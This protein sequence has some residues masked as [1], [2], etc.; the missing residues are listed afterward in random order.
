MDSIFYTLSV[1]LVIGALMAAAMR[2]M[3][4][5]LIIGY[6]L[7][8]IVAGP[9]IL[10]ITKS[11]DALAVFSEIGIALLLFIVGLGLNPKAISEVGRTAALVGTIQVGVITALGYLVGSALGLSH[12]AAAFLGASVA[13]SSTIII[14]KLLSDKHEQNRLYGKIAI[15]VSLVQDLIA[16]ALVIVTSAGSGSSVQFGSTISL[17]LKGL[18]IAGLIYWFS[19]EFLPRYHKLVASSQ[20]FLFLFAIAAGLGSAALFAKIGLSSEIGALLAGVCLA[21]APYAQEIASRLRPLRDFF[22]V[23]FF[24]TLGAGLG[25]TH[26]ASQL[27]IILAAVAIVVI[28]KPLVAIASMGWLGYTKRTSFKTAIALAQVSEFSI[29]LVILAQKRG[30]I[31]QDVTS[32]ITLIA[33]LSIAVSS[34]LVDFSDRLFKL[35]E[36]RLG[37]FE[38][39]R[40]HG[41]PAVPPRYELVLFGYQK[42]GHEFIKTFKQLGRPFVVIDYDPEIIEH[43]ERLKISSLYGD[44]TDPELLAEAGVDKARLV[45]SS[46]TDQNTNLQLLD[47][48]S[49]QNPEAVV[50]CQAESAK[51][52]VELYER[53]ASYVMLPH[54]IGSEQIGAFIKKSGLAKRPFNK[55]RAGHLNRLRAQQKKLVDAPAA[56]GESQKL[57]QTIV[58]NLAGLRPKS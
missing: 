5:P 6:I 41:E 2:A 28:A 15:G 51:A 23:I 1:V 7:T 20:E 45:V 42:G 29:V 37:L 43:L 36:T 38:R 52:A 54:Y 57:T 3:R 19:V 34:Y 16:I 22:L 58:K 53:G 39:R 31:S 44:A 46:I 56:E 55:Y 25:F 26:F 47:Y 4:Q 18:L 12:T 13:F 49:S 40:P 8:G 48:I 10:G 11:P 50:I 32:A 21:Q 24:I 27:P 9:A 33:L 35:T 14:L 30:L 17:A